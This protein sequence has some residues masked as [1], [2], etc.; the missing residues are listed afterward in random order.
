MTAL[1]QPRVMNNIGL[2]AIG[3]NEGARLVRCLESVRSVTKRVYVDSG[4]SDGSV[5]FAAAQGVS[6]V[7]L[8]TP[9]N[10]TAARARN[11][12][13]SR[14]LAEDPSLEF[15]QMIDGDCE[16]QP[17]WLE[18]GL[19]ALRGNPRLAVVYGRLRE[20]FPQSSVYNALCDDEWNSPVGEASGMLG[21]ALCR[22]AALREVDFYN[23]GI[24][25]GEDSELALR[26]RKA[27]WRIECIASEMALHDAAIFHLRQ[28]WGRTR[29]SGHCYAELA[30]LHPDSRDPDWERSVRSILVWGALMPLAVLLATAAAVVADPRWLILALILIAP[31]PLKMYTLA[32]RQRRRGLTSKVAWASG[33]LLMLGKVP[34][35]LGALSYYRNRLL[36]RKSRLIE[37]K[38]AKTA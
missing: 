17:G 3:R 2:V 26:L 21:I 4:S 27:G 35:L 31:W 9:P 20:R 12:G 11:A 28:W 32:H 38:R 18:S 1:E 25:A 15:V 10:F 14:L 5:A 16:M 30:R 33:I 29:R 37:Y 6:V 34:Q 24:I 36:G 7:E 8:P 23:A 13:L 19:A 22:V